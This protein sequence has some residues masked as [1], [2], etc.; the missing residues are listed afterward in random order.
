MASDVHLTSRF[1]VLEDD[2]F[3]PHDTRFSKGEPVNRGEPPQCPQCGG[4]MGMLTW[5]PPY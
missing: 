3:G 4:S 5:L 2:V 1:F